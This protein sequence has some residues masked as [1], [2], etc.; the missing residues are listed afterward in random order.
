MWN[1]L[2][3]INVG[4]YT[5]KGLAR[6]IARAFRKEGDRAGQVRVQK[7]AVEGNDPHRGHRRVCEGDRVR[8][9]VRRGMAEAKLS[10]FRWLSPFFKLV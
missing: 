5:G 3:L 8:V 7:Q 9:G 10:C 4:V 1:E 2:G 6:K